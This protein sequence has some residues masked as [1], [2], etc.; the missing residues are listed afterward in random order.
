MVSATYLQIKKL[1]CLA[2]ILLDIVLM[3]GEMNCNKFIIA[4]GIFL[5]N[6]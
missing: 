1:P 6:Y 2:K 3:E 5:H 4:K